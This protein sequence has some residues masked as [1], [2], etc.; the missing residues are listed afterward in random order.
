MYPFCLSVLAR[1]QL[2]TELDTQQEYRLQRKQQTKHETN[3]RLF[4]PVHRSSFTPIIDVGTRLPAIPAHSIFLI[5]WQKMFSKISQSSSELPPMHPY[6]PYIRTKG[7]YV[8]VNGAAVDGSSSY[9][10]GAKTG[11]SPFEGPHNIC[12]IY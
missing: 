7:S 12:T 11:Y 3:L 8:V 9:L 5:S 1:P 2:L 10:R 4:L 6:L